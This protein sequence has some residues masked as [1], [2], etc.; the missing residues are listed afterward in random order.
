[1]ALGQGKAQRNSVAFQFYLEL[2]RIHFQFKSEFDSNTLGFHST[3]ELDRIVF[4]YK[5]VAQILVSL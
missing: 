4:E 5:F 1:M 3:V 2:I